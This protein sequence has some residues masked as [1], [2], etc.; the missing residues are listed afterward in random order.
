MSL[1]KRALKGTIA[2]VIAL[3]AQLGLQIVSVPV[4]LDRW[5]EE[6]YGVWLAINSLFGLLI[7]IDAGHQNYVGNEFL[8]LVPVGIPETRRMIQ[9]GVGG[10][11]VTAVL[12]LLVT[13]ILAAAGLLTVLAGASENRATDVLIC[14]GALLVMWISMGSVMGVLVRLYQPLGDYARATWLGIIQR[15]A[16]GFT[17]VIVA[18]VG[19]TLRTAVIVVAVV[20]FSFGCFVFVDVTR[21]MHPYRPFFAIPE[22]KLVGRNLFRSIWVTAAGFIT[23]AQQHFFLLVVA[24]AL[25][26]VAAL[27]AYTTMRTVANI[28]LQG[29]NT[30]SA[31]LLPDLVRF[32]ASGEWAKLELLLRAVSALSAFAMGL[33]LALA[34][35]ILPWAYAIWTRGH[36]EFNSPLY[37]LLALAVLVR[38]TGSPVS[39]MLAGLNA[40][41]PMI[42][43]AT[44]QFVVTVGLGAIFVP[45]DGLRGAGGAVL[46]GEIFGS[47]VV[48]FLVLKLRERALTNLIE[49][50]AMILAMAPVMFVAVAFLSHAYLSLPP[51][52]TTSFACALLMLLSASLWRSFPENVR[53]RLVRIVRPT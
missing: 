5:G 50:R 36:T 14:V 6:E 33:G 16:V 43:I 20:W 52:A 8:Q 1:E 37:A 9:A 41:G 49:P 51:I 30:L 15:T 44:V 18:I 24:A 3:V 4:L 38:V 28:F 40:L 42:A 34:L 45:L 23:Q 25:G 31:P 26:G 48:P 22:W 12:E 46:L 27:P 7:T 10:A 13:S 32:R 35:P 11:F 2:S 29:A 21:R 47:L 17:P 53:S 19:G 39:S